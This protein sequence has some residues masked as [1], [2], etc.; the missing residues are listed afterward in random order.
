MLTAPLA[1]LQPLQQAHTT[2]TRLVAP[3]PHPQHPSH[4]PAPIPHSWNTCQALTAHPRIAPSV[5]GSQHPFPAHSTPGRLTA[6]IP[7]PQ[8]LSHTQYPCQAHRTS[9]KP[10]P[11]VSQLSCHSCST[12]GSLTAPT[13]VPQP[14]HWSQNTHTHPTTS[15]R[16][17]QPHTSP[18]AL[19]H[20]CPCT[21]LPPQG[22][23]TQKVSPL[24][25]IPPT[26]PVSGTGVMAGVPHPHPLCWAGSPCPPPWASARW[27]QLVQG[28]HESEE[29]GLPLLW[30]KG[31]AI[32][33]GCRGRRR[34]GHHRESKG[35]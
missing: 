32:A 31:P 34:Q 25:A 26:I 18:L 11:A 28:C 27:P 33:R 1:A 35:P 15:T 10:V 17:P 16:V 14:P 21:P 20:S 8:H 2:H 19:P 7:H 24:G 22:G 30:S 23:C 4:T 13:P 29:L 6:P 3:I 5:P 12:H 9:A